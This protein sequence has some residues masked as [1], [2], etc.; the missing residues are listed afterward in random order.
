[1]GWEAWYTV[2]LLGL[3]V[4]GLARNWAVPDVLVLGTLALIMLAEALTGTDRLPGP[5]A[6]VA[7]FGNSGLITVAALFA[8]V[9]GL[10]QTGAMTRVTTPLLGRP[11][12]AAAAQARL[13]FPVAGLSAFLNNTPVVAM[14]LPVVSDLCKRTGI[15][16]AKLFIPLSYASI[17]GGMC[18][19]IGTSTNL[20]INGLVLAEPGMKGLGMFDIAWVGLPAALVGLG[21]LMLFGRWLL[22]DRKP[23]IDRDGDPRQYTVEMVVESAGPLVGYTIEQAGLRHLPGLFLIEIERRGEVIEAVD[24][25]AKLQADDR[26]VFAGIVESVVDL[27]KIR[28]LIPATDQVFKLDA[29]VAQRRL[30]EAVVS[31]RCPLVGMTIR[32]GRFRTRYNAAVIAVARS[33][34]R[35]RKKIGDIVLR[36]GDT[37]LL[38]AIGS[39]AEQHRNGR[40]FFLVSQVSD[41]APPRHNRAWVALGILVA[42][43]VVVAAGFISMLTAALVA[44]GAMV[45]T[46]CCT[47]T[48]ARRSINWQVL[49]VIGGALGLGMAMTTSGAAE[50]ITRGL[51]GLAGGNPWLVLLMVYLTTSLFTEFITNN[52]AAVLVFPVALAASHAMDVSVM[53]FV[54]TVMIAASASFATP[55]GY[56]TNLMVYGPGGYRFTDF[57]RVGLPMNVIV[58]VVTVTLAPIMFPFAG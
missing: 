20:V 22:P 45:V 57:L 42:M 23:V 25:S 49:L 19:L 15:S 52:A 35:V 51:I 31:D 37:L 33:G 8:V 2:L 56:Q 26:L 6:A 32:D 46:R 24:S 10:V 36:P 53:P 47:G 54:V 16:P 21:S 29:P 44:A 1:M 3:L 48:E 50:S 30:I 7:G 5:A 9:E 55:L 11:K 4:L 12:S 40:D 28:G 13:M 43:V 34:E 38:E 39:F 41:S 14:F 17:L 58:M 27:R 18:T